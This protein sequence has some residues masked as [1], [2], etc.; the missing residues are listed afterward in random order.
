[1]F[2]SAEVKKQIFNYLAITLGTIIFVIGTKGMIIAAKLTMSGVNGLAIIIHYLM[3][4]PVGAI[5]VALNIP[6]IIIGWK[7]I[8]REFGY[9]TIYAVI[10]SSVL[11]DRIGNFSLVP[12]HDMFLGSLFGGIV[13]G[14]GVGIVFRYGGSVGGVGVLAKFF[15]Q[16]FGASIGSV[17]F[18][19]NSFIILTTALT[20]GSQTALYSI[21][22]IFAAGKMMDVVQAGL[23]TKSVF[24]ISD[25][26]QQLTTGI[27]QE[28]GR[29][30]TI[31]KGEGSFS[32]ED[33]KILLC[34]ISW[35]DLYRLKNLVK[36]IDPDAFLIIG[37]AKE[38]FGKGFKTI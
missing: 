12:A 15:N 18:I 3:N 36:G 10:I 24:I 25:Y 29:G 38:I 8:N 28:L 4:L 14:L 22:A 33:K 23:P 34:A 9:K 31:L 11:I 13:Y 27:H 1:M 21:L 20:I 5:V 37:D 17:N 7:Y 35:E 2:R 26:A 16:R 6:L 30:V 32:G 19:L